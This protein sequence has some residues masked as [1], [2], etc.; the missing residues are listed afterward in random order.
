VVRSEVIGRYTL[1]AKIGS[2]GMA[3]VHLGRLSGAAGF[4]RTVAIKRMHRELASQPRFVSMFLDEARLAARIRHPNV[5]PTLDVVATDDELF[6]VLEY[7]QG[8][9]LARL[10]QTTT[11]LGQRVPVAVVAGVASGVLHGL[12]AAHEATSEN[13]APL[14]LVHRDVSPHNV[15]IG[16]DG[17]ARVLDFGVAKAADRLQTTREGQIKGKLSY[18]APEQ[19]NKAPVTRRSDVYSAAVVTWEALTGQRLFYDDNPG[20]VLKNLLTAEVVPPSTH[21]PE[22][23]PE[24][25]AI[26]LRGLARDPEQ[27]FATARDMARAI[28]AAVPVALPSTV[29]EWVERTA[30]DAIREQAA[31]L[32]EVESSSRPSRRPPVA[33]ELAVNRESAIEPELAASEATMAAPASSTE[34][35]MSSLPSS[36]SI[37]ARSAARSRRRGL[38]VGAVLGLIGAA[39]VIAWRMGSVASTAA[40]AASPVLSEH[41]KAVQQPAALGAAISAGPPPPAPSLATKLDAAAPHAARR[42][43]RRAIP[44]TAHSAEPAYDPYGHL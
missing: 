24:L 8:E 2:G 19:V 15:I 11:R 13:G 40:P 38:L 37:Q 23:R 10:L 9:T 12:H 32:A 41:A 7:V 18:M 3:T 5:V 42:R 14:G 39:I 28:E 26:V 44:R 21:A 20:A 17:I 31:L 25:D 35:T 1:F 6:L 22:V 29:G 43:V 16:V 30:H 34:A 27:R 4:S 36:V 33:A